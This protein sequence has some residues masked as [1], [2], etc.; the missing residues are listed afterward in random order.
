MGHSERLWSLHPW[1]YLKDTWTLSLA[2]CSGWPCLYKRLDHMTSRGPFQP[3]PFSDSVECLQGLA[4]EQD[5]RVI[6]SSIPHHSTFEWTF[7]VT[8]NS[9][10][11]CFLVYLLFLSMLISS[12]LLSHFFHLLRT[13]QYRSSWNVT[14]LYSLAVWVQSRLNFQ[15]MDWVFPLPDSLNSFTVTCAEYCVHYVSHT[16]VITSALLF[17]LP[18]MFS[19]F[20]QTSWKEDTE[21]KLFVKYYLT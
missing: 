2:T 3:Q 5:M 17:L 8:N 18:S 4:D 1:R 14:R 20:L 7:L 9:F 13:T 15:S 10:S 19:P 21:G 11:P 16:N 12:V 6:H